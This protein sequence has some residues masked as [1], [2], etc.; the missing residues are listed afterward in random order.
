MRVLTKYNKCAYNDDVSALLY[1][2]R[3]MDVNQ[4]TQQT[5]LP[6]WVPPQ[7]IHDFSH[8]AEYKVF[9]EALRG[10]EWA[11]DFAR[12]M[13]DGWKW[14]KAA[15]IAWVSQPKEMREPR[16]KGAFAELIGCSRSKI[17]EME[18]DPLIST[19][20]LKFR[21]RA[22]ADNIPDVMNALT[23]SA[24]NANYKHHADRKIFLE[25]VGEY[26]PRMGL[27]LEQD[28]FNRQEMEEMMEEFQYELLI[29]LS[30]FFAQGGN[31]GLLIEHVEKL[32]D[33]LQ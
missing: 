16:F 18:R 28:A 11:E 26:T 30:Q 31:V 5:L 29:T 12:L 4:P 14:R 24:T 13:Y 10:L 33:A 32:T 2:N 6:A 20:I 17:A 8:D 22:L 3:K 19:A 1:T 7:E 15:F 23:E 9:V 25:M 21:R 27:A